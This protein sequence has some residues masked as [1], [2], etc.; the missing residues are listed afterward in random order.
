MDVQTV[1]NAIRFLVSQGLVSEI[2]RPGLTKKLKVTPRSLLQPPVKDGGGSLL[3]PPPNGGVTPPPIHEEPPVLDGVTPPPNEGGRSYSP[4]VTPL[5]GSHEGICVCGKYSKSYCLD[6]KTR[7][8]PCMQDLID[9][10][11]ECAKEYELDWELC[12]LFMTAHTEDW[13][14]M[15]D[16]ESKLLE[17]VCGGVEFDDNS[18]SK[19]L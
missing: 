14:D 3:S 10:C 12:Q 18:L 11:F 13:V 2:N 4:E 1:T 8:I 15:D 5:S 7:T 9:I 6:T 17:E 19:Q 16:V